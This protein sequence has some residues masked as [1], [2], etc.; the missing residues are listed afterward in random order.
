[1]I[2]GKRGTR[3]PLAS[4]RV[5]RASTPWLSQSKFNRGIIHSINNQTE[6]NLIIQSRSLNIGQLNGTPDR[7]WTL[8]I[9]RNFRS[10][11]FSPIDSRHL[12][13]DTR[14][15]NPSI[16]CRIKTLPIYTPSSFLPFFPF[17]TNSPTRPQFF[18]HFALTLDR[19]HPRP[20]RP[21]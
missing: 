3:T 9:N 4:A 7:N 6:I 15:P 18:S 16:L 2:T 12:T 8:K 5:T 20:L 11:I 13:R 19:F 1:M 17:F 14:G 10:S 21:L